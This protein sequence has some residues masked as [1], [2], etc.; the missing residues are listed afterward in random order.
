MFSIPF[1]FNTLIAILVFGEARVI[2]DKAHGNYPTINTDIFTKNLPP[3]IVLSTFDNKTIDRVG[4]V[5]EVIVNSTS[6]F[7]IA[8][9]GNSRI[10]KIDENGTV[11]KIQS[12]GNFFHKP[13]G[14]TAS[15]NYIYYTEAQQAFYQMDFDLNLKQTIKRNNFL[16]TIWYDLN[17]DLLYVA[18]EGPPPIENPG[19]IYVYRVINE[20]YF[21]LISTITVDT[22]PYGLMVLMGNLYVGDENNN[23]IVYNQNKQ[24][25]MVNNICEELTEQE[26]WSILAD[27]NG[28]IVFPCG[29]TNEI[30]LYSNST[31]TFTRATT[32]DS[33][34]GVYLDSKS[35]LFVGTAN[36]LLIYY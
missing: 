28:N 5:V 24:I 13:V 35:R 8:D 1:F 31:R 20:T 34:R 21:S 25:T 3:K 29:E 15:K 6:Y 19:F 12:T 2:E 23:Y 22:A 33:P 4:A 26:I 32:I 14:I 30:V 17:T 9:W 7:F 16:E 36:H 18:D 11:L 10:V 27:V